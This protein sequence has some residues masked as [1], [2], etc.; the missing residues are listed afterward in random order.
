MNFEQ[1]M[2]QAT[3]VAKQQDA[4]LMERARQKRRED[5]ERRHREEKAAREREDAQALVNRKRDLQDKKQKLLSDQSKKGEKRRTPVDKTTSA[6]PRTSTPKTVQ[7]KS[8]ASFLPE[9]KVTI[10]LTWGVLDNN[11]K[12]THSI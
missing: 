11:N 3:Q 12:K 7:R 9:K 6:K 2:A 1:L 10:K 8:V 5:D 4:S